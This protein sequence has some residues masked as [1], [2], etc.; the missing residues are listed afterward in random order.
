[1]L[2]TGTLRRLRSSKE[3][4]M[5]GFGRGAA[6][7]AGTAALVGALSAL[8]PQLAAADSAVK[9]RDFGL[10]LAPPATAAVRPK[11]EKVAK[12][13]APKAPKPENTEIKSLTLTLASVDTSRMGHMLLVATDGAVWEQTDG[14]DVPRLPA[15]GETVQVSKGMF[16][17]YLCQ[18]THWQSVRC[19]RDK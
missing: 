14:D 7:A 8:V 15:A 2:S 13:K 6:R 3:E 11:K 12:V 5:T 19:Q 9:K 10:G 4:E 18:V 1:M 17:G 16:G